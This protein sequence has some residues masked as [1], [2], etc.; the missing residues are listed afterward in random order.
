MRYRDGKING[1]TSRIHYFSEWIYQNTRKG[2]VED[3]TPSLSGNISF[4]F[5][6]SFMSKNPSYYRHLKNNPDAINAIKQTEN[7]INEKVNLRHV[8]KKDLSK[9]KQQ[10][11][12]GDIIAITTSKK[13][14]DISHLGFAV[15]DRKIL[16]ML[17]A[18]TD[19]KKV[20]ITSKSLQTYL[21]AIPSHAGIVVLR[22]K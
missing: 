9:C 19:E 1:Y 5:K 10:I 15:W 13:G 8:P 20:V 14:L 11:K 3:V 12:N 17:H 21:D 7:H 6:V 4:P 2:I 22:M 16:K 18:S